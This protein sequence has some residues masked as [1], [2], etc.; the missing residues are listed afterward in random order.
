MVRIE[1]RPS[2]QRELYS[3]I[4]LE[5]DPNYAPALHGLAAA[6]PRFEPTAAF[7]FGSPLKNAMQ[8]GEHSIE[9]WDY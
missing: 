1:G 2:L 9:V 5:L 7:R 3:R 4:C 6:C 8:S